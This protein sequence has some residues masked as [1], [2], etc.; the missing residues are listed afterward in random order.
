MSLGI[1]IGQIRRQEAVA[2]G[3]TSPVYGIT[4][5][6][7]GMRPSA[8]MAAVRRNAGTSAHSVTVEGSMDYNGPWTV[9]ATIIDEVPVKI[10]TSIPNYIRTN[11]GTMTGGTADIII[12]G[13]VN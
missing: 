8:L 3:V 6:A 5:D 10:A 13:A 9:L 4:P 2:Q 1:R 7:Q 11:A 12:T